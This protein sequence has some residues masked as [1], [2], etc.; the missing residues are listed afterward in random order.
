MLDSVG[1]PP[2]YGIAVR[3]DGLSYFTELY[4]GGVGITTV[5]TR[6]VNGFIATGQI[7]TGVTFSPDGNTA[8]VTNQYSNNVSVIDVPSA[9]VVAT[10][11]I[12]N[13]LSPYVV[14][15]SPD[16]TRLF[17][18]TNGS[19]VFIVDTRTLQFI[20]SV[21]VG[22]AP[23]AFAV[24]PDARLIYVSAAFGASVS[25]I[26]MFTGTVLRTFSVSG[27]PQDMAVTRDGEF[28]YVANEAGFLDQ[29]TL[30]SGQ[31]TAT[32]PLAGG[33]FGMGVT[34]DDAQAYVGIPDKGVVQ[35]FNLQSRKL[36]QTLTVGGNPRRIA[37]SQ[38]GHIGAI[39]NLNGYVSFVR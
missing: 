34:P 8:Y 38:Q 36:A 14:R 5:Q 28:L 31:V 7:P 9:T 13:G 30:L 35:I 18:S 17:I 22:F 2:A 39:A 32:I 25:E 23:N 12:P 21:Q 16:G 3:E 27:I 11:P 6:T 20:A 37:F 1:T 29:V 10:I 26:D 15:V 24:N 4:N 19:T 33:A